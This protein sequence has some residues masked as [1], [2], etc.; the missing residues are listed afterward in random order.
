MVTEALANGGDIFVDGE[1]EFGELGSRAEAGVHED[2]GS[3][4]GAGGEDD[5]F[6]GK[7]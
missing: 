2:L 3:V 7:V 6:G 5:L 1:V 4:E